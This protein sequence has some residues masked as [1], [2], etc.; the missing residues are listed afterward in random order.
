MTTN[1][2]IFN[3]QVI[4]DLPS[5]SP[6][7]SPPVVQWINV[8]SRNI[9]HIF[10]YDASLTPTSVGAG[11][12]SDQ[13]FTVTGLSTGHRP[14]VTPPALT[15]GLGIAYARVTA[16]NTLQIRFFNMTGG[17]LTPAAGTYSI[18]AIRT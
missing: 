4:P 3:F 2:G 13:T 15:A 5:I 10:C 18:T 1:N 14:I 17:P 16:T 11:T 8:V 9:R 12:T 7:G 6:W